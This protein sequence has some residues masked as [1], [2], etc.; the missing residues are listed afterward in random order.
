M[1]LTTALLVP[2]A[3]LLPA[4]EIAAPLAPVQEDGGRCER[5]WQQSAEL[6]EPARATPDDFPPVS[7]RSW[8]GSFVAHGFQP[9]TANQ[10]RIEQSL[11]IRIAPHPRASAPQVRPDMLVGIPQRAIGSSFDERRIGLCLPIRSIA[12]VQPNGGNDLILYLRDR[13][14]VRAQLE[15][16]CRARDFYSGFYI[17]GGDG[18][19][20]VDRDM[21]QSRSGAN[22]KISEI[23]QLIET[24]D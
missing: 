1:S 9:D 4:G 2:F 5:V 11:R 8:P 7:I 20:C 21:L 10:V 19:L 14:M 22:C 12:G 3:L 24:G 15:R 16:S 23:R 6:D 17:A 18:R 13:R